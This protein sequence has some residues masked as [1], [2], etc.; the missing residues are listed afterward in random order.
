MDPID[1]YQPSR[2]SPKGILVIFALNTVKFIRRFFVLF[3]AFGLSLSKKESFSFLSTTNLTLIIL[4]IF[5]VIFVFAILKYLNFKFH[6][7]EDEFHLSAGIINKDATIIPKSKIQNVY[8]KQNFIQQL[9]NVVSLTIETA[10]DDKAEIEINALDRTT[11]L[12]LKKQLFRRTQGVDPNLVGQSSQNNMFFKASVMRLFLEG[13][14]QNHIKSLLVIVSFLFGLYHEFEKYLQDFGISDRLISSVNFETGSFLN[15]ILANIFIVI[16]AILVSIVFSVLNTFVSNFNLEV[17]ENNETLE[18]NK[19]LFNKFSLILTP[20][21]IQN[22]I[23]KTNRLKQYLGLHTVSIKQAMV[24]KKQQR[25]FKVVAL[26]KPQVLLLIQKIF[27]RY[28]GEGTYKKP[29]I[30]YKRLLI[31]RSSFFGALSN[32]P[33]FLILGN[34]FWLINSVIITWIVLFVHF[35]YKKASYQI[36]EEYLTVNGGFIDRV[37]NISE[38][39]KIQ[40]VE[41]KQS[42]FQKRK[43][44]ASLYIATASNQV[45]IPYITEDTAKSIHDYLLFK[46]ESAGRDWK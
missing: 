18:I 4:G 37:R 16:L 21:K 23:V 2:Q 27:T 34:S 31:W 6:L 40:S 11:A 8:I 12:D 5:L 30:Y 38:L 7:V 20:V 43:K 15:L 35:T 39:H 17:V 29:N 26:E 3:V 45:K 41:L 1:F 25:N 13:I 42:I 36:T 24:N 33:A 9:I 19:G 22:I 28:N 10:G 44:I 32:I 46:I 14:S